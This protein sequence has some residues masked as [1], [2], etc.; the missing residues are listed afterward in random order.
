MHKHRTQAPSTGYL[1]RDTGL[2]LIFIDPLSSPP[3]F[4]MSSSLE[5]WHRLTGISVLFGSKVTPL[6]ANKA[7]E[8]EQEICKELLSRR[9]IAFK[10]MEELSKWGI[11]IEDSFATTLAQLKE[12]APK[13][14]PHSFPDDLGE[15]GEHWRVLGEM[16]TDLLWKSRDIAGEA[17][18]ISKDYAKVFIETML[19]TQNRGIPEIK[20]AI[21]NY[22]QTLEQKKSRVQSAIDSF[23]DLAQRITVFKRELMVFAETRG[24]PLNP[25]PLQDLDRE[26]S[27][28]VANLEKYQQEARSTSTATGIFPLASGAFSIILDT[29]PKGSNGAIAKTSVDSLSR[30]LKTITNKQ[31]DGIKKLENLKEQR[32][33]IFD[34]LQGI[35]MLH[36]FLEE[37]TE[38]MTAF[39][40]RI[41]KIYSIWNIIQVDLRAVNEYLNNMD[42]SVSENTTMDMFISRVSS[43]RDLYLLIAEGFGVYQRALDV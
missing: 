10:E 1:P 20:S 13:G 7:V 21:S 29:F 32:Q 8:V 14:D 43:G 31:I 39:E 19:T 11:S 24:V 12:T 22:I 6:E 40:D 4:N 9:E 26:I 42:H 17:S 2:C 18:V 34:G 25:S 38:S 23:G 27:T 30:P 37:Y 33:R 35:Q 3:S 28:I 16:F 41:R 15:L 36:V 5:R